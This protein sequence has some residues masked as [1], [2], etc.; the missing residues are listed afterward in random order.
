MQTPT[1]ARALANQADTLAAKGDLVGAISR[2]KEALRL[3]PRFLQGWLQ[4]SRLL[5]ETGNYAEAV[6]VTQA[7]ERF[8]PLEADFRQI[9]HHMQTR[10]FGAAESVAQAM[11]KKEAG[12]PRAVFT[13]AHVAGLKNNPEG[14]VKALEYG[15]SHAPANQVLRNALVGAQES[16]GDYSGAIDTARTLV[17]TEESFAAY[18]M[19]VSILLRYGQNEELL[20]VCDRAKPF[21][22]NDALKLSE[23]ELVRGQILRVMGRREESIAAY[24][25]CLRLNARNAGA[26]WALADM[27]TFDFSGD[28]RHAIQALLSDPQLRAPEK[29][30]AMFALA[31]AQESA[32][33]LDASMSAYADANRLYANPTFDPKQ[34]ESAIEARVKAFDS[35]ALQAICDPA[36]KGPVPIFILGLPRSGSTLLEQILASH[37][38]IEGTIEQPVLP[39]I[40]RKAHA[41]CALKHGGDFLEKIGALS[42]A[43]LSELGQAYLDNGAVFRTEGR[44]YFT[45][46]LPFNFLHIGLIAKVLPQAI[47]IDIRRNPLDCGLSLFKQHFPTGVDFSYDLNHIGVYYNAYL[48]L[49]DHWHSVLPGRI[50]TLQHEHVVRDPEAKIR[51]LLDHI[52]LPFESACVNFHQT[53]RAVRTASS[54]QVRQP[55]NTRGIG[56]WRKVEA[57]LGPLKQAL[58]EQTLARFAGEF[59]A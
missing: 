12:H 53:E 59:D 52:G 40:A 25:T 26:W 8:D 50:L 42:S 36:P 45:D 13:L 17:R 49:M 44:A 47:I 39:S 4:L 29:C 54:E 51:E 32:G 9:Q 24:R 30:V 21:A 18:W 57:H 10:A 48:K 14:Q 7:A 11:L 31:K 3:D 20:E 37:S 55:I 27:K 28:D 56:A 33:D 38:E 6:Q 43:Q 46:K 15:L 58:G 19:L 5:F 22:E 2:L 34:F 41:I 35:A 1:S 23:I 16:A